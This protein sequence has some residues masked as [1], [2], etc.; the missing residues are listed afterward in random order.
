MR[1]H[2]G[3]TIQ[4][5]HAG[6]GQQRRAGGTGKRCAEQKI[7]VARH[8]KQRRVAGECRQLGL[9]S[10]GKG[11]AVVVAE[12]KAKEVAQNIQRV[13][14]PLMG[15]QK[16]SKV[17]I[18]RG[19]ARGKVQVSQKQGTGRH[20]AQSKQRE[21][22]RI[23]AANPRCR[24]GKDS[25][26]HPPPLSQNQPSMISAFSTTTSSSGTSWWP[27]RR[28]VLTVF[29]WSMTSRPSTTSPNTQ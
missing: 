22:S 5:H 26:S 16:G 4:R 9:D 18:E 17:G 20:R 21:E 10:A 13:N 29:I 28:P 2:I 24:R 15:G 11:A 23:V 27:S 6:V 12:P 7:T 19:G 3:L 25:A 1:Q 14:L 8:D